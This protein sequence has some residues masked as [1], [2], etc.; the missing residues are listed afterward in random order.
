MIC[1]FNS[2]IAGLKKCDKRSSL[3][4]MFKENFCF[5]VE[6]E[7]GQKAALCE[8]KFMQQ[9]QLYHCPSNKTCWPKWITISVFV[10]S[11]LLDV[12]RSYHLSTWVFDRKLFLFLRQNR[13]KNFD[14]LNFLIWVKLKLCVKMKLMT[15]IISRKIEKFWM[16]TIQKSWFHYRS[17]SKTTQVFSNNQ[18]SLE[19]HGEKNYWC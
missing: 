10:G 4:W 16:I 17:S 13:K 9:A 1:R 12:Y 6:K 7:F 15:A 19:K 11:R 18:E 2:R 3:T 5:P 8:S 14:L